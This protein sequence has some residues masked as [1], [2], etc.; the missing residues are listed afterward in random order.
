MFDPAAIDARL[1]RREME[2]RELECT[3][4]AILPAEANPISP[5]AAVRARA[6]E[7]LTSCI[8]K[9]GELGSRLLCGPVYAPIGYLQDR[10]GTDEEWDWAVTCFQK[11]GD[12]LEDHQIDLAIEPVNRSETFFLRKASEAV[13]LCERIDHPRIGITLDTFHANIEEKTIPGA[14]RECGS[15]LKHIHA[16]END[17]GQLGSGHVDFRGLIAELLTSG[18][19]GYLMIE[20]FGF[21]PGERDSL[22]AMLGIYDG[23]PEEIAYG[24]ADYLRK[25]IEERQD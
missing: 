25:L 22:A 6:V 12:V 16:S 7:Y 17:R 24:G 9:A 21:I 10:R 2:K 14:V 15:R 5:D 18:Y 8:K 11:L 3:V 20:G 4:C 1:L 23:S 13:L 19:S